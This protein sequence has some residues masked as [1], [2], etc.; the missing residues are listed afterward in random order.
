MYDNFYEPSTASNLCNM[1]L[2]TPQ[3]T[4]G[5]G[6]GTNTKELKTGYYSHRKNVK[7]ALIETFD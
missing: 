7:M 1:D 4:T 3:Q 2:C 5:L 6:Y